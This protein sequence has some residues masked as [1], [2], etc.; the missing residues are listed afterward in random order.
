LTSPGT[1][2]RRWRGLIPLCT[3]MCSGTC[4]S[5]PYLECGCVPGRSTLASSE[6]CQSLE[7]GWR[8]EGMRR[9]LRVGWTFVGERQGHRA[10]QREPVAVGVPGR[11][12]AVRSLWS[13]R[14]VCLSWNWLGISSHLT[15]LCMT[16][17][18]EN[19]YG[20]GV[21]NVWL[22]SRCGFRAGKS[23]TGRVDG[24]QS[25]S[26]VAQVNCVLV[27]PWRYDDVTAVLD[28]FTIG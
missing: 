2:R 11:T 14:C 24:R 7:R 16:L 19:R 10:D 1:R 13:I 28:S 22:R 9:S 25:P 15:G 21:H 4:W 18:L 5:C 17:E 27:T 23:K 3:P 12:G 26:S 6:K 20:W 8:T